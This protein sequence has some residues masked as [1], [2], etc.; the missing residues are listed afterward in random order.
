[1]DTI[2]NFFNSLLTNMDQTITGV[3][4]NRYLF[5]TVV[6]ITLLIGSLVP[7]RLS[8]NILS[9]YDT[10]LSRILMI[11][12]IYYVSQKNVPLAIL[13]LTA[14]IVLMNTQSKQRFNI[15]LISLFRRSAFDSRQRVFDK[16]TTQAKL[17]RLVGRIAKILGKMRKRSIKKAPKELTK[18]AIKAKTLAKSLG[19]STP[20]VV[21]ELIPSNLIDKLLNEKK[22]SKVDADK[23]KTI[24]SNTLLELV[25][26][27]E[28]L[29]L[30]ESSPKSISPKS[31]SPSITITPKT[32]SPVTTSVL[33]TAVVTPKVIKSETFDGF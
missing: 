25:K 29:R 13:M 10:P 11:G 16:I 26:M 21:K 20:K 33:K 18:M 8:H 1:M 3:L 7:S 4:D 22:I 28:I 24:Q 31:V 15:M 30:S 9:L 5:I 12:F 19:K 23:L 6:V 27:P 32:T 14:T 17:D 2:N